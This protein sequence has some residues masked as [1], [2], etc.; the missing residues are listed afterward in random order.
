[1]PIWSA[2]PWK[3][4][5]EGSYGSGAD[6]AKKRNHTVVVTIRKDVKPRRVVAVKRVQKEP[7]PSMA[8]YLDERVKPYGGT[9][10]HDNTGIGQVVHDLLHHSSD[11]FNM[12][13]RDR[14]DL[15]SEYIAALEKGELVWPRDDT[16]QALAAAYSEHKYAT[17]DDVYKGTKDGTGKHHLPD[18]ISAGALAWRAVNTPD[19]AS[20]MQLPNDPNAAHLQQPPER[21]R[22]SNYMAGGGINR[23]PGLGRTRR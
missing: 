9:S 10:T 6:W 4:D 15:L 21:S 23:P 11:P 1:M 3:P 18:T 12:V 16:N 14:A 19:S 2:T 7:W 22:L 5:P 17:R 8:G 13:G 20:V